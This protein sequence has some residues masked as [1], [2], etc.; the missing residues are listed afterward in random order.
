M[1]YTFHSVLSY[2]STFTVDNIEK[3]R[4]EFFN[5]KFTRIVKFNRTKPGEFGISLKKL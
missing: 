2:I 1:P 4:R 3:I 5:L